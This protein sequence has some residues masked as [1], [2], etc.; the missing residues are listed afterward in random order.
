M[1]W[2]QAPH[3]ARA[4]PVDLAV[5]AIVAV[6]FAATLHGV[7]SVAQDPRLAVNHLNLP[8]MIGG[9]YLA[10][11]AAV[12]TDRDFQ[13]LW[14]V[15]V[16]AVAAKILGWGVLAVLGEGS[17]FGTTLRVGFGSVWTAFVLVL[18]Y[19]LLI[20]QRKLGIPARQRAAALVCVMVAVG[21]IIMAAGRM[22]WLLTGL[23]LGI[24]VLL[25]EGAARIRYFTVGALAG[26]AVFIVM[27]TYR[28][29]IFETIR[30]MAGTL[31]F[32]DAASREAT[33]STSVRVYEFLNIHAQL[34]DHGNLL[35]GDGPGSTFSDRYYPFPFGLGEGDYSIEEQER[36]EFRNSHTLFTQLMLHVGYGGMAAYLG[37]LAYAWLALYR[38]RR[39]LDGPGA[40]TVALA[41]LAFLPAMAYMAWNA[42]ANM[43]LGLTLGLAGALYALGHVPEYE[44]ATDVKQAEAAR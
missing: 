22:L 5:L 31:R 20:Q 39:A 40:R 2:R 27:L 4:T 26:T 13:F 9:L 36:R 41:L 33:P 19:G 34:V 25:S 42:K 21:L 29:E 44:Q 11:R 38:L 14:S 1:R 3:N 30:A 35:L 43:L 28:P 37:A 7:N 32:W 6:Y 17:A 12:A 15:F 24:V 10:V 18:V 8:I 23:A 16:L